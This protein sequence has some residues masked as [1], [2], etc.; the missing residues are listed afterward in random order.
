MKK[1][2]RWY[3]G[4]AS[5][6]K[7]LIYSYALLVSIPLLVLGIYSYRISRRNLLMQTEDTIKSN[8]S[9]I[10]SSLNDSMQRENDNIRYLISVLQ[11]GVSGKTAECRERY[12]RPCKGTE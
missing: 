8:V 4:N 9:I 5:I 6:R 11:C 3:Y 10:A 2:L 12:E 1:I 7:K